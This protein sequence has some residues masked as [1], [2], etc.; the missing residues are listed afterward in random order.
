QQYVN[1]ETQARSFQTQMRDSKELLELLRSAQSDPS[2]IV[3]TPNSLL[4]SQPAL[5]RLKDGLVDAQLVTAK[6]QGTRS[7][8]HPRVLAAHEAEQGIRRDLFEE[9]QSAIGAAEAE[10]ELNTARHAAARKQLTELESRLASLA[11]KR[12]EYSNRVAALETSRQTLDRVKQQLNTAQASRSASEK[13]HVLTP[14]DEPETG[15]SREGIGMATMSMAGLLGGLSLG[16]GL[17]LLTGGPS[18]VAPVAASPERTQESQAAP[19][20]PT[21]E[22]WESAENTSVS[23]NDE[24]STE[25]AEAARRVAEAEAA[26]KAARE[27]AERENAQRKARI[28]ELN[29]R[30]GVVINSAKPSAAEDAEFDEPPKPISSVDDLGSTEVSEDSVAEQTHVATEEQPEE[31]EVPEPIQATQFLDNPVEQNAE[32]EESE[33]LA[34]PSLVDSSDSTVKP[35]TPVETEKETEEP[36]PWANYV[37]PVA[38]KQPEE[39]EERAVPQQAARPEVPTVSSPEKTLMLN[40]GVLPSTGGTLEEAEQEFAGMSLEEAMNAAVESR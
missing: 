1:L 20:P 33:E 38:E 5:R 16:V 19:T 26:E 21:R 7:A 37:M 25:K 32:S 10:L 4:A 17:V 39:T 15:S 14:L 11:E 2:Q 36:N 29:A 18:V 30:E 12:A 8:E 27:E 9:L 34:A 35:E 40:P 13:A 24:S 31:S 28:A 23:T 3:A 6:L 22:W